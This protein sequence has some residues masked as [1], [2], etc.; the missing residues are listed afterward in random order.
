MRKA[1]NEE[2]A[3]LGRDLE[4]DAVIMQ[5]VIN[6]RKLWKRVN[7]GKREKGGPVHISGKDGQRLTDQT[8][9]MDR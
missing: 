1:K 4:K 5:L 8:D 6:Q 3:Q 7:E 2:W 9:T